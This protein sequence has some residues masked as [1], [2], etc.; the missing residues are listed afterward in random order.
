[1]TLYKARVASMLDNVQQIR[2]TEQV[3]I[4][5]AVDKFMNEVKPVHN[6]APSGRIPARMIDEVRKICSTEQVSHRNA[7]D[8]YMA[9]L[10]EA[11]SVQSLI[12]FRGKF[13]RQ[14][15]D[16]YLKSFRL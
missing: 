9:E 3:P 14:I 15:I 11:R 7:L 6:Y 13:Q 8:K 10:G 12:R 2:L 1:M 5:Y 16:G 4:V